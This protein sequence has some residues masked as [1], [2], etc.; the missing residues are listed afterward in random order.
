MPV[1]LGHDTVYFVDTYQ[2][3]GAAVV[4]TLGIEDCGR[5]GKNIKFFVSTLWKYIRSKRSRGTAPLIPNFG[6][7]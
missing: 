7:R 6:T 3:F 4:A 1:F 5:K 2:C